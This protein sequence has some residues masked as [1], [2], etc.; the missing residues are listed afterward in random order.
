[1]KTPEVLQRMCHVTFI[2]KTENRKSKDILKILKWL[3]VSVHPCLPTFEDVVHINPLTT[4]DAFWHRQ[5]LATCY[6][7][8]QSVLKIHSALAERGGTEGGGWVHCSG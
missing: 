1:M 5:I 2:R 6:Q 3:I 7:L 4:D 8:V